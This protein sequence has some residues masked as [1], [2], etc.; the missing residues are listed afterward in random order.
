MSANNILIKN[1]YLATS[2]DISKS[3]ILISD[4]KII[5]I[6]LL[7]DMDADHIIDASDKYVLPGIIDPQVHF[8]DPGMTHKE[9]IHTGS[10]LFLKQSAL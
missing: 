3:D 1:G 8:R 2:R 10:F 9:D 4:G 7:S 5:K 6:G